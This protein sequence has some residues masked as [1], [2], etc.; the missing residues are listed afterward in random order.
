M[1]VA[2]IFQLV[3]LILILGIGGSV[4][5]P[6]GIPPG[7]EDPVVSRV[8]PE[9]CLFYMSW[10]GTAQPD[11]TGT[12]QTEQLLAEQ[13][14]Q[15]CLSQL[16]QRVMGALKRGTER[17]EQA[18]AIVEP[19]VTVVKAVATSPAAIFVSRFDPRDPRPDIRGG[20]LVNLGERAEAIAQ[21]LATIEDVL[22]EETAKRPAGPADWHEF[23]LEP[24]GPIVQWAVK[25]T[26]L[27]VGVGEGE[28]DRILARREQ[29]SPA[30]L[31]ELRQQVAVPRLASLVYVNVARI[32]EL[33]DAQM[34]PD[35]RRI[36]SA[37]GLKQ[38]QSVA[39]VT[40]LDDDGCVSKTQ[41]AV[42]GPFTGLLSV[43]SGGS[44]AKEHL[45][46]IP[47][48]ATLA[49]AAR[50]DLAK[51][52]DELLEV[53]GRIEPREREGMLGAVG[54]FEE[55]MKVS[56]SQD[57]FAAVGDVWRV[58]NSPGEGGLVVTGLTA[59]VDLRDRDRLVAANG[60]LI[61][62]SLLGGAARGFSD[63]NGPRRGPR[64]SH[65]KFGEQTIFTMSLIGEPMP[66]APSWCITER[67]L[68]VAL[69]PQN[70]RAY[71]SRGSAGDSL[72][73]VPETAEL[74]AGGVA[75]MAV[76][77]CDTPGLFRLFYPVIQMV[78]QYASSEFQR[79]GIDLDIS[80]L[81]SAPS[82]LR[83][84]Q[85]TVTAVRRTKMGVV[86]ETRQTL[87]GGG[88]GL[89]AAQLLFGVGPMLPWRVGPPP[90]GQNRSINN[91]KQIA[92]GLHNYHDVYRGFPA[93]AG[94]RPGDRKPG[95]PPVSWRVL[96][97]PYVEQAALYDQYRFDE[98]WDSEHNKKL[99]ATMPAVF[100]APGS[101]AVGEGKTNYLAVVG[102]QYAFAKEKGRRIAEFPDGTSNT[103]MVV[104]V[105][106][107][108]AVPWTK[109]EDF[110]PDEK[111]PSAGLIGLRA[112]RFLACLTDGSVQAIPGGLDAATYKALFT[113]AGGEP[114]SPWELSRAG[115]PVSPPAAPKAVVTASE[116]E[117]PAEW[118]VPLR[119]QGR[120]TCNGAPVEGARVVFQPSDGASGT[121][122]S[123]STD[124]MGRFTLT[125]PGLN[126]GATSRRYKVSIVKLDASAPPNA[127]PRHLLPEK[128]SL[129][130]TSALIVEITR[131]AAGM[132]LPVGRA[133]L[134]VEHAPDGQECPS[135]G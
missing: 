124:S 6:L 7:P 112:G 72:A 68:V 1:V 84:L 89:M 95:Q 103:I 13:E 111:D 19:I 132:D 102:D 65:A 14:I 11:P 66:F 98:P 110:T 135:Y 5:L 44:L 69:Y 119:A 62:S 130:R 55:Q 4:G 30:W 39:S 80:L 50:F 77:Y 56:I 123:A 104:E 113:R 101:K 60:K 3:P 121:P 115:G 33:V 17:D 21:A 47:Q 40:G 43:F 99:A 35:D 129:P 94:P 57:I 67:E 88:G 53:V 122:L 126:D 26:H 37:L 70:V 63:E 78:A 9:E 31:A 114:V 54:Q 79:N 82:F 46:V 118:P 25:Q 83:H 117:K 90:T 91:M 27:I 75:P 10:A 49:A 74:F 51:A 73:D 96:I 41:L 18:A 116:L 87:P 61:F 38:I 52:Y 32:L 92:L 36:M 59:V 107:E 71:L 86:I 106:D 22:S 105:S 120:V 8:A 133:L 131:R 76:G 108:R 109:P 64:I 93:S 81:P 16:E 28:A 23:P 100:K 85:P 48:D 128:Y 134:P 42:D 58:Y 125:A 127:P 29:E 34:S 12:N 15:E 24:D 97:L 45:A 20:A 2:S